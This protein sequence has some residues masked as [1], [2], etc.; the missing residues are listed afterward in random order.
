[1]SDIDVEEEGTIDTSP[2]PVS[3]NNIEKILQQMK[4]CVCKIKKEKLKGSGFFAKLP[5]KSTLKNVLITNKHILNKD[6]L[7]VGKILKVSINNEEEYKEIE[8]DGKRLILVDEEKDLTII[9]IREKDKINN[10]LDIDERYNLNNIEER[11]KNESLYVLNYAKGKDVVVS[12]GLLNKMENEYLYHL[13]STEGGSSGSPIISLDSLKLIGIHRGFY[14]PNKCNIGLFIRYA[15]DE[16]NKI[17][18]NVLKKEENKLNENSINEI[19]INPSINSNY[20]NK[21]D[22]MNYNSEIKKLHQMVAYFY[23]NFSKERFLKYSNIIKE[24]FKKNKEF[25]KLDDKDIFAISL[26]EKDFENDKIIREVSGNGYKFYMNLN[27]YLMNP[28]IENKDYESIAYFTSEFMYCLDSYGIKNNIHF[29]NEMTLYRGLKLDYN[30]L[31][32]YEKSKGKI[33]LIP[34]FTSC[35]KFKDVAKC[36]AKVNNKS[37]FSVMFNIKLNHGK[38]WLSNGIDIQ[39]ISEY[40]GEEEIII[41]AFSFFYVRDVQIDVNNRAA[42]I[43]LETIG[44]KEILEKKMKNGKDVEYNEIENIIQIKNN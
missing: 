19:K 5:Y 9:E 21:S 3:I 22:I 27:K 1:M 13:C 25:Q 12:Y 2:I 29:R 32:L 41:Q 37:K 8:M 40:K 26:F 16:F 11:Y 4:K 7:K 23:G 39:E 38:N 24:L 15:I 10:Y 18:N 14:K 17:E 30:N 34:A 36:F 31:L 44:R 42:E 28:K 35:S 43:Y 6:D 33:I 20:D